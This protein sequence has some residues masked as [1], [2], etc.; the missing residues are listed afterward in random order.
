MIHTSTL[1]I[2]GFG[3]FFVNLLNLLVHL[4]NP[5]ETTKLFPVCWTVDKDTDKGPYSQ[6]S[7]FPS[8]H[9]WM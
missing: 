9:V 3:I 2:T 1:G 5:V 8:G 7:G 6:S 4:G